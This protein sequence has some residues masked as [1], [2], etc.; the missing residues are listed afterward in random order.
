[1]LRQAWIATLA[2]ALLATA[3]PA[4]S[5]EIRY[6]PPT[7]VPQEL[8]DIPVVMD[9]DLWM[10]VA[11][12]G[13]TLKLKPVGAHRFEGYLDVRVRCN[14]NARLLYSIVATGVISGHYSCFPEYADIDVPGGTATIGARLDN[15]DLSNVPG[16]SRNVHVATI[17][18]KVIPRP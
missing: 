17:M 6:W 12:Q 15:A 5:L 14:F 3:A 11:V 7:F 9:V 13:E 1:M 8:V 10:D 2:A 4:G 18:V 16:G